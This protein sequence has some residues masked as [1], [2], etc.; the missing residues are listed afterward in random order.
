MCAQSRCTPTT[1]L[2]GPRTLHRAQT[3]D[4]T[5]ATRG[6]PLLYVTGSNLEQPAITALLTYRVRSS[7]RAVLASRPFFM[8]SRDARLGVQRCGRR[9]MR[10]RQAA[11]GAHPTVGG[12][13]SHTA[14]SSRTTLVFLSSL[15]H[16]SLSIVLSLS[17]LL[18]PSLVPPSRRVRALCLCASQVGSTPAY[19][20]LG[21]VCDRPDVGG[22]HWRVP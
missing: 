14:P 15:P 16:R 19:P 18:S 3:A 17:S 9:C 8:G 5:G 7:A 12:A 1:M 6:L 4:A 13:D 22:E 21:C 11:R 2:L 10:C 20:R